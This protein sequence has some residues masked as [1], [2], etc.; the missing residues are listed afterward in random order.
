MSKQTDK[1]L[2]LTRRGFLKFAAFSTA[3]ITLGKYLRDSVLRHEMAEERWSAEPG[4]ESWGLAVCRQCPAG[5]GLRVRL[6]DGDARKLEGNPFCPIARGATCPKGQAGLQALYN[7]DRLLGPV[8]RM[9]ARGQNK[10]QRLSW[11]NALA[12]IN[13]K[14]G[15]LRAQHNPQA[16]AWIAERNDATQG[17]LIRRF[18]SAYGSP[19]LFEFVDLRDNA[20]R[21]SMNACQGID[22]LPAYDFENARF[23]LSFGTPVLESWLSPTWMARQYG[24]LH[25]GRTEWRGRLVQVEPRMSP[26]AVKADE[27]IPVNPGTE[28]ALALA[29]AHVMIREDL[30]DRAFI[31]EH[32]NGFMDWTD[33]DGRAQDGFRTRV[34]RDYAPSAVVE[35]TGVP[36]TIILRLAREFAANKPAIAIGEHVPLSGGASLAWATQALNALNGMI[37]REGG[38]LAQRELPLR[39][40]PPLMPDPEA[41]RGLAAPMLPNSLPRLA[42]ALDEAKPYGIE[43]LLVSSSRFF[44]VTPEAERFFRAAKKIPFIVSFSNTLDDSAAFADLILPDHSPLEKWLDV[45]PLPVNGAP[46]WAVSQPALEPL[47]DTRHTGEVVLELARKLGGSM[48][49][50]FPWKDA[51]EVMRFVAEGLFEARRGAPF[52]TLYESSW[53]EQLEA[54]G[55]WIPS[56]KTSDE[57]WKQLLAS[58][59]WFDPIYQYERWGR[60]FKT[61]SGGFE[62][63][64]RAPAAEGAA[65]WLPAVTPQWVGAEREYPLKL[66]VFTVLTTAGLENPNQPFL[67]ETLGPH[68][69]ARWDNWLE[70]HPETAHRLHIK[71]GDWVWL[72]SPRGRARLRVRLYVGA[73]PD[74]VSTMIGHDRRLGGVLDAKYGQTVADLLAYRPDP[75]GMPDQ[76]PA[77]TRVKIYKATGGG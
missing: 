16:L 27:W 71:E 65:P 25:R 70:L 30:Y 76:P 35:L 67:Q 52:T 36:E 37:D 23:I 19:N 44:S 50:A 15:A 47:L 53:I 40:L 8:R 75:S 54:G 12:E 2:R 46:V 7:P 9:G 32:A 21:A 77:M 38:L 43:A 29:L 31:E 41:Q 18:M 11:D 74:V 33:R 45:A 22:E 64:P 5:C 4:I 28:T 17:Q 51:P 24:H 3:G 20:A 59:G 63:V 57:L 13:A 39:P 26:T 14:L 56:A 60:V 1:T 10:W 69:Y 66:H 34:L 72:E 55:W 62:F 61:P 42:A 68:V 48:A 6:V 58:G 73:L 49:K